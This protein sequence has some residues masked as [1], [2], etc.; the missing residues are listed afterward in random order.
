MGLLLEVF[1]RRS[2]E[3]RLQAFKVRALGFKFGPC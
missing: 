2:L 3:R 1:V